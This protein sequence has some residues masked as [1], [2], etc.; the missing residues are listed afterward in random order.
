[1][2]GGLRLEVLRS[3]QPSTLTQREFCPPSSVSPGPGTDPAM[4]RPHPARS[5]VYHPDVVPTAGP[6]QQPP[7][8]DRTLGVT[9]RSVHQLGRDA[10][11]GMVGTIRVHVRQVR[12]S[13]K[14]L[15]RPSTRSPDQGP[16]DDLT[17][18]VA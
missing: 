18:M 9:D 1:M 14:A 6:E 8:G 3:E 13:A 12:D 11:V 16:I 15:S 2:S 10:T 17:V 5:S 7:V 4:A